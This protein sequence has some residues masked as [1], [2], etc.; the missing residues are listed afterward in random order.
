MAV[1]LPGPFLARVLFFGVCVY[2]LGSFAR[3]SRVN[4]TW[5]Y[6]GESQWEEVFLCS[7]SERGS[8]VGVHIPNIMR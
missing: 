5:P 4:G 7:A 1:R 3:N 6:P 2:P 8:D